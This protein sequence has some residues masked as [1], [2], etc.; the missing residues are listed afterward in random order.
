MG[1]KRPGAL[2]PAGNGDESV[3][4]TVWSTS[5][6]GKANEAFERFDWITADQAERL[7]GTACVQRIVLTRDLLNPIGLWLKLLFNS[8]RSDQ[9]C[10]NAGAFE[11]K[12]KIQHVISKTL[13]PDQEE[14]HPELTI[15]LHFNHQPDDESDCCWDNF[16]VVY[17]VQQNDPVSLV[18]F[19]K[20]RH[21]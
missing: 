11:L 17:K 5:R 16:D 12:E 3:P 20:Q 4:S 10:Q 2:A 14:I 13:A 7:C 1:S 21:N 18:R 15:D 19:P 6:E 9:S 8:L